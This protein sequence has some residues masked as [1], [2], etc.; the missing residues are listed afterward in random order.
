MKL[1]CAVYKGEGKPLIKHKEKTKKMFSGLSSFVRVSTCQ[2]IEIYSE[3]DLS[4][5]EGM[6]RLAYP[7]SMQHLAEVLSGTDSGLF[8]EIEIYLQIKEAVKKAKEEKHLSPELE[9]CFMKA[10]EISEKIR[11]KHKL[12]NSWI[13][14]IKSEIGGRKEVFVYGDGSLAKSLKDSLEKSEISGGIGNADA[15]IVLKKG[16]RI[17]EGSNAKVINL[18][19]EQSKEEEMKMQEFFSRPEKSEIEKIKE[20]IRKELNEY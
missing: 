2:R 15:V 18:T 13:N 16:L 11:E 6:K 4:A 9:S 3:K 7:D 20:D 1:N 19:G 12:N 17:P 10:F 8:G 5:P 14:S